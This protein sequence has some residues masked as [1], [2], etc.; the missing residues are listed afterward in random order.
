MSIAK[1]A[2][3]AL[4]LNNIINPSMRNHYEYAIE[5]MMERILS[6]ASICLMAICFGKLIPAVL[7]SG[8]FL[9]LRRH[10]GGYH[11]KSFIIC[12]VESMTTFSVI[13]L[14]G[15]LVV[16]YRILIN[17]GLF[18]S[19]IIIMFVGTVNHPNMNFDEKEL[20][21]SKKSARYVLM[22]EIFIILSLDFIGAS[23]RYLGFMSFGIIL[24][25][26]SIVMA[27]V[28]KQEV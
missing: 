6:L 10:T 18:L 26:M 25:A 20:R 19:F 8:F 15:D 13:M 27:K 7:F 24:C 11:A 9:L 4:I 22:L 12:Y 23:E 28:S 3:N 5:V 21:E 14:L 16:S 17:I 2:V 1:A